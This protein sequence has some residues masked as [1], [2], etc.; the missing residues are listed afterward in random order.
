MVDKCPP[1]ELSHISP[2]EF[3]CPELSPD[4]QWG[5]GSD[6]RFVSLALFPLYGENKNSS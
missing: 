3:S 4:Q 6:L 5:A 1:T 2:K